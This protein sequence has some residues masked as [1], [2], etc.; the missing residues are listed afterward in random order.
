M[1]LEEIRTKIIELYYK[2]ALP[3]TEICS[4]LDLSRGTFYNLMRRFNLPLKETRRG[5]VALS[6]PCPQCGNAKSTVVITDTTPSSITRVRKC[7]ECR[8]FFTT[9]EEVI[10]GK[11][12]STH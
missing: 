3:T 1:E 6:P 8:C 11:K 7:K 10:N 12:V 5:P 4:A 9:K 2:E